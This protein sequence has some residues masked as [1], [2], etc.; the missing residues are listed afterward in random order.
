MVEKRGRGR[1]KKNPESEVKRGPGR[2]K[3]DPT[4]RGPGRPRKA[5]E[6]RPVGHPFFSPTIADRIK[7]EQLLACGMSQ[8]DIARAIGITKPTLIKH[9]PEEIATGALRKRAEVIQMIF[10]SADKGVVSAQKYLEEVTRITTAAD[11][12]HARGAV[13]AK[14][15]EVIVP[16][17]PKLGKKEERNLAA[18]RVAESGLYAP[19]R[20]PKLVVNNKP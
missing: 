10:K 8:D 1:P 17:A 4:K 7:V 16:R 2:P 18:E 6:K 9:F 3:K 15:E 11:A 20:A 14:D 12:V 19:P 13:P 5:V